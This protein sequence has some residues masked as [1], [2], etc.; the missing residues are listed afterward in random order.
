MIF[1]KLG[2]KKIWRGK[3]GSEILLDILVFSIIFL[4]GGRGEGIWLFVGFSCYG[5]K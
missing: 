4:R 3:C 5:G 1:K 2:N